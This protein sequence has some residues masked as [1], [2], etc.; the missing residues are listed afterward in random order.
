MTAF[1]FIRPTTITDS[2]G[3]FARSTTATYFD[4]DGVMQTAAIDV[5]RIGYD[6]V[7][8]AHTGLILEGAATNVVRNATANCAGTSTAASA[9]T[10][11]GPD[12]V[13]ATK[14][15]PTAGAVSYPGSGDPAAQTFANAQSFGQYTDYTFSGYFAPYGPLNYQPYIVIT[16]STNPGNEVYAL[17]FFDSTSGVFYGKTLTGG[18]ADLTAPE[19][20]LMPCGMWLV[21]WTVRFTQQALLR[22]LVYHYLQVANA[23]RTAVYTADGLSG[24]QRA[25]HQFEVGSAATSYIPTTSAAVTRAADV[26]TGSGLIYTDVPEN[27]YAAWVG[28]TT[29]TALTSYVIRTT[30]TTH[31]VYQCL[32]THTTAAT[33]EDNTTGVTPKWLEIGP[34]NRWGMF[35]R[36]VGT[37]TTQA[38]SMTYLLKPGR[39]NSLGLLGI[40]AD[41]VEVSLVA[42]DEIVYA[43]SI[44]LN[45]GNSVGDWYQYFYEPIYSTDAVAITN[46][47]DAALMAIPA[48]GDGVLCVRFLATAGDVTCGVL[49]VGLY[50][51]LGTTLYDPTIGI[52][53]YSR[54]SVDAFGNYDIT[55]RTYSKRMSAT[56]M[57]ESTD[58]DN[59]ARLLT[60]YRATPVVWVGADNLYSSLIVYGF[61]KDWEETIKGPTHSTCNIQI[62]GLT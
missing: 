5:P 22:T 25:C 9:G 17:V 32:V 58:V 10:A 1:K 56:L 54:K 16:A 34:T 33:P 50:A 7:T 21:K 30:A 62:E 48:Y 2:S 4:V 35:D 24:I 29:Y 39:A 37:E 20:T 11:T 55:E 18:F 51:E 46:L 47:L 57:V 60:Q 27:D 59:T 43:A 12:G 8:H 26:V 42:N 36:K 31:K 15:I 3:S 19:A 61:A 13:A 6:P 23:S 38:T 40:D 28:G 49:A 52:I 14:V 45:S 44:D 41:S 53:D